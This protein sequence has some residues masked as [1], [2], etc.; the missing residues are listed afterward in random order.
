MN[1]SNCEEMR[2]PLGE[3]TKEEAKSNKDEGQGRE[4]LSLSRS[5]RQTQLRRLGSSRRL[6][7]T[8]TRENAVELQ[9]SSLRSPSLLRS[10]SGRSSALA[11]ETTANETRRSDFHL[12]TP[13]SLIAQPKPPTESFFIMVTGSIESA[14]SPSFFANDE[15]YCTYEYQFGNQWSVVHGINT[16]TTQVGR[17]GR[18]EKNERGLNEISWNFPVDAAFQ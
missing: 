9:S 15:L 2:S 16:G 12:M 5:R 4:S 6:I 11:A 17:Q 18:K 1:A 8:T 7:Q 3:D 10:P 13:N 14:I